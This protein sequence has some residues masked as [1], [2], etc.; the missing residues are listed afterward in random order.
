MLPFASPMWVPG[1][2]SRLL[3]SS[4]VVG[5][6]VITLISPFC[7]AA[8][9]TDS[10][11]QLGGRDV[12]WNVNFWDF[13]LDPPAGSAH[14]PMKTD[15]KYPYTSQCQ[16]GACTGGNYRPPIVDTKDPI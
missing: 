13:Q 10:I 3:A 5:F 8:F 12:R 15:P 9:G 6:L 2:P 11:P 1:L 14:G 4:V 7:V 16:N